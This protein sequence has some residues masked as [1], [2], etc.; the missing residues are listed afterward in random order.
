MCIFLCLKSD[1]EMMICLKIKL[2][3]FVKKFFS[4]KKRHPM[5]FNFTKEE[6]IFNIDK[7]SETVIK[8]KNVNVGMKL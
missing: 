8:I 1:W 4:S 6:M 2:G 5:K 3:V 7:N